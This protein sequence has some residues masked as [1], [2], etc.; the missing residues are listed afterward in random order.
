MNKNPVYFII[1]F[2]VLVGVLGVSISVHKVQAQYPIIRIKADGSIDPPSANI[3]TSDYI[4][5]YFN[6]SI[7]A[8]ILVERN[9][10]TV[11]GAGFTLQGVDGAYGFNLTNVSNVTIK[12]VEIK[13]FER[14]IWLDTS[15][16]NT[17]SG[18]NITAGN[19][20][21]IYFWRSA[22][23]TVSGNSITNNGEGIMLGD[24][25][26]NAIS[27]NT[28]ANNSEGIRLY[29]SSNFNTIIGNEITNNH[30][31]IGLDGS[32]DNKVYHNNFVDNTQQVYFYRSGYVNSWDNEME[33]NYW[34]NY[35]GVDRDPIDGI[36]DTSHIIEASNRDNFPLMG[37]FHSFN[38][39]VGKHVNVMSNS[40][41]DSFEYFESN[42]TIRMYLSSMTD[43][44]TFGFCRL[45][46]PKSLIPPPVS[47]I[48]NDGSTEL[49]C[50]DDAVAVNTTHRWMYFAYEHSTN[51]IVIIP[52]FPSLLILP[53]FM[54]LTLL[55]AVAYRRKD[56][57]NLKALA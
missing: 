40:T 44:Q 6:G 5:Y 11:D 48:I 22:N 12:N 42:S 52:E 19:G 28:V 14:G 18:N 39:S 2:A 32:S 55:A 53:L 43:N 21:S 57:A 10:V 35:T 8:S 46:I 1:F 38:T 24:S 23:N 16:N 9:N 37:M 13:A 30:N 15:S 27:G 17:I 36:G 45:V 20:L 56:R 47:V 50:Y 31:G 4:S 29:D 26:F 49:L 34:S 54:A 41:V 7:N 25:N 33:G 3:T 51:K